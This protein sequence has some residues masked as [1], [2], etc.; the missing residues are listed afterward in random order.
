V[1][2]RNEAGPYYKND[3]HFIETYFELN[4]IEAGKGIPNGKIRYWYDGQLLISS[5]S[6]LMR[7]AAHPDMMF[8]QLF[9]G[10]YIGVG[11]PVDQTWWVDDLTLADGILTTQTHPADAD[12]LDFTFLPNPSHGTIRYQMAPDE[13]GPDDYQL[14]IYGLS[15][16]LLLRQSHLSAVG[17][18]RLPLPAGMY[19]A[20]VSRSSGKRGYQKITIL[21]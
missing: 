13:A 8:D 7:T 17:V 19:I 11:S 2:F 21:D 20:S 16:N 15:G 14:E 9:Y 5:D 4:T 1:Y 3:W 6:I 12:P 10:P 18:L